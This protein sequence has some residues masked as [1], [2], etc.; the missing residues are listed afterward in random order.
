MPST[1]L[2]DQ[3]DVEEPADADVLE[4]PDVLAVPDGL[5]QVGDTP[6]VGV[7][8]PAAA[9]SRFS[10]ARTDAADAMP[11]YLVP[12]DTTIGVV[13]VRVGTRVAPGR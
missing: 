13:A 3:P 10:A 7:G 5:A 2:P 12:S 9:P 4:V 8:V 6:A 1:T 11:R